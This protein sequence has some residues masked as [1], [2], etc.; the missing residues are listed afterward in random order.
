MNFIRLKLNVNETLIKNV[1]DKKNCLILPDI[2]NLNVPKARTLRTWYLNTLLF[3][4]HYLF[5]TQLCM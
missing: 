3:I 1:F 4:H 5:K 2:Y